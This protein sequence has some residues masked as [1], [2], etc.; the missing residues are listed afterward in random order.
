MKNL[1]FLV[2]VLLTGLAY[3]QTDVHVITDF[4]VQGKMIAIFREDGTIEPMTDMMVK[5]E[6]ELIFF[7]EPGSAYTL[8]ID[9][10]RYD[11]WPVTDTTSYGMIT[12]DGPD[13]HSGWL[14][15]WSM[16]KTFN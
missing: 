5:S 7:L 16:P 9:E 3:A 13:C 12:N 1:L 2:A 4:S 8:V 14:D 10:Q 6:N 15:L 11:I